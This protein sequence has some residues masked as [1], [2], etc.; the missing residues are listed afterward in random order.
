MQIPLY[1][2]LLYC[3]SFIFCLNAY[4][5]DDSLRAKSIRELTHTLRNNYFDRAIAHEMA[6]TI[7][8]RFEAG[9]YDTAYNMDEFFHLLTNDL[10]SI[11][12]DDHVLV[13][14]QS[15]PYYD[16]SDFSDQPVPTKRM[17]RKT[18]SRL[19]K[20]RKY[21]MALLK[22]E[23]ISIGEVKLVNENTGYLQVLDFYADPKK[24]QKITM[25]K[26]AAFLN[27]SHNLI[28]DLRRNPG[29]YARQMEYFI[30]YFTP[31]K[32]TY[33][34]LQSFAFRYDS[35]GVEKAFSYKYKVYS[36]SFIN[37]SFF[38]PEIFVLIDVHTFSAG[39]GAAY[40]LK[41]I[42]PGVK[43]IGERTSGGFGSGAGFGWYR[44]FDAWIPNGRLIDEVRNIVINE[45]GI[46]PDIIVP[47]D[48][49]YDV[50]I[51]M[52]NQVQPAGKND[53]KYL[54]KMRREKPLSAAAFDLS[55]YTGNYLKAVVEER[56][57]QLV[58]NYDKWAPVRLYPIETD[59]FSAPG[60]IREVRFFRTGDGVITGIRLEF[61]NTFKEIFLKR[62]VYKP[63]SVLGVR[64]SK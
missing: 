53:T 50:A 9:V 48:S 16:Y 6:D 24:P 37:R 22:K 5:Q 56:E 15:Q 60:L 32:N 62:P 64:S 51:R 52:A 36:D 39:E 7:T 44:Y 21:L 2:P 13:R 42:Y 11:C 28:I 20:Q 46:E 47:A 26:A 4:S 58:L 3:L 25:K 31:Q 14:G 29:G 49:A 10:R 30:S 17:Q 57:G 27:G 34:Y 1:R 55:R 61:S 35:A 19:E 40:L 23:A 18:T 33:L 8:R 59:V 12:K 54:A 43:I 41:K 38:Q 45:G 63:E